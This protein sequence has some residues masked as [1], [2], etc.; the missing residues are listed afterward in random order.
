M[1]E[2]LEPTVLT[3]QAPFEGGDNETRNDLD[4]GPGGA[5]VRRG[6]PSFNPSSLIPGR[7]V[8]AAA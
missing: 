7:S 6:F 3:I 1:H 4:V 8:G 2:M 5:L